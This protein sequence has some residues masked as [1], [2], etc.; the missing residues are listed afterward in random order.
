MEL[1]RYKNSSQSP[2]ILGALIV[3]PGDEAEHTG[4]P[5]R[6]FEP[7]N[8][9]ACAITEYFAKHLTDP[10]RPERPINPLVGGIYLPSSTDP[11]DEL[12]IV[13]EAPAGAPLY[14]ATLEV[15]LPH[16]LLADGEVICALGWPRPTWLEAA[17]D[18]ALQVMRYFEANDDNPALLRS[19]WC[20]F[21]QALVLPELPAQPQREPWF[22][23][24]PE[25]DVSPRQRTR[26]SLRRVA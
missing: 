9:A 17:N 22:P 4:W 10:W 23:Q 15:D 18:P 5:V 19:P 14:R 6:H 3:N 26:R 20:E 24:G 11:R 16:R 12:R 1:P 25:Q 7:V 8:P 21:R 2:A 13:E